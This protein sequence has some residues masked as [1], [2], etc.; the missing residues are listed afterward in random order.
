MTIFA[1]YLQCYM[2]FYKGIKVNIS[3]ATQKFIVALI[4]KINPIQIITIIA[5]NTKNSLNLVP[6]T[7]ENSFQSC[8]KFLAIVKQKFG[9][10]L[11]CHG[12]CY[13]AIAN[14]SYAKHLINCS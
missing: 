9:I 5:E 1:L 14:C 4:Y 3:A 11:K 6:H 8:E 2:L 13:I 12:Y 10:F 7:I